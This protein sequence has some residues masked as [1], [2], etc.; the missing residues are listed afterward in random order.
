MCVRMYGCAGGKGVLF[1]RG[2]PTQQST[3]SSLACT[4]ASVV[5]QPSRSLGP[6]PEYCVLFVLVQLFG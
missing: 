3:S 4:S 2:I 6:T 1:N 5:R